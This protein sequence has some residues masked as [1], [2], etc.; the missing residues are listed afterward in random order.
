MQTDAVGLEGNL[1]AGGKIKKQVYESDNRNH[2]WDQERRKP[3]EETQTTMPQQDPNESRMEEMSK[4][5][6]SINQQMSNL[7][8][9]PKMPTIAPPR[10]NLGYRRPKNPQFL[11]QDRRNDDQN[12]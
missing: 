5:L 4:A 1:I 7:K 8:S 12:I 6:K 11:Q 2:D 9:D 10:N 3:R